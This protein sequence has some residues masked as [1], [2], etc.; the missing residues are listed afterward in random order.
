MPQSVLD[1]ARVLELLPIRLS[2]SALE[3]VLFLSK[4]ELEAHDATTLTVSVTPDRLDL[5]S[6]GGLG[7]ALAGA[8]DFAH[9][10]PPVAERALGGPET[11]LVVAPST[12]P[13]RPEIAGVLVHAPND[14]GLDPGLLAEAI[15][16]QELLHA[17]VGRDRRAASLGIYPVER[18]RFPVRYALEPMD[19]VEF[20]PLDGTERV[21]ANSFFATHPLAA[22]YGG[23]GRSRDD[24][25]TL[26]DADG[27]ILSLP[28]VLNSRTCGEARVGDR[29][30]LL[31]STGTRERAVHEALGLLLLPFVAR[32]WAVAPVPVEADEGRHEDG[33]ARFAPRTVELPSAAVS[34]IL[35][36]PLASAEVERRLARARL[37]CHPAAH[38]WKVEVPVWRPDLLTAVD[39]VE[40]LAIAAPIRPE[41]GL[42][43]PSRTRGR[44]R[45]ETHFRRK[46]AAALLGLGL[47]APYTSLLVSEAAAR[48][49]PGSHPIPLA[50]PVSAEYS[51]L[52][53]RLLASHLE[54]LAHNTRHGYPQRFGEVGPVLVRSA[55]ADSGAETRYHAGVIVA[56][57]SAGFAEV[58][59]IADYLFRGFDVAPVREPAELPAT[60][61]GR[62]ARARLAG[63][64]VAEIGELDPAVLTELGVPVPVAW[65]ELDLSALWTLLGRRDG[66]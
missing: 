32:G 45:A 30:L 10:L 22:R 27:A 61:S 55:S 52:R 9:G 41:D 4:A 47:P 59:G 34:E 5:L 64:P 65:V 48:R 31:E 20:V 63:E 51:Y 56:S 25:L 42:L 1:R 38:G 18:L 17:T 23:F 15:R 66:D 62:A 33:R 44:L 54:I 50:N 24:C 49:L 57:D 40:D 16:F 60:L 28:P 11:K 2:E 8:L 13:L 19:H 7:L 58:A 53:D 21:G 39:L 35:G 14:V 6:E 43:P 37:T 12:A 29:L 46:V 36:A 3:D 26:R